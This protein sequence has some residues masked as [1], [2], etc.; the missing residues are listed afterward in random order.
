MELLISPA[1]MSAGV[2]TMLTSVIVIRCYAGGYCYPLLC[3]RILLSV[4][5]QNDAF[6]DGVEKESNVETMRGMRG[7]GGILNLAK[8]EI[9]YF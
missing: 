2:A 4:A 7:M 3:R 5:T 6:E 1:I 9:E 8:V